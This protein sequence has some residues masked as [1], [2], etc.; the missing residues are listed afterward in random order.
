MKKSYLFGAMASAM[1]MFSACSSE[2]DVLVNDGSDLSAAKQEIVLQVKSTGTGLT[3]RAGRPLLS[4]AAGQ[5]IDNVVVFICDSEHKIEKKI[6]VEN[7]MNDAKPYAQGYEYPIEL[8]SGEKVELEGSGIVYAVGYSNGSFYNVEAFTGLDEGDYIDE[9]LTLKL[10]SGL[11]EEIFAGEI[12][13]AVND[14]GGFK[15][16]PVLNRQVA[17][18][19]GYFESIPYYE[20]AAKLRLVTYSAL[21]SNLVLGKFFNSDFET[22]GNN[23]TGLYAMNGFGKDNG[24][25]LY[26]IDLTKWFKTIQD[27]N[28]DGCIDKDIWTLDSNKM[29][30]L[31]KETD[32]NA[33]WNVSD[34]FVNDKASF[35]PGSVFAGNFIVPFA[36]A[37]QVDGKDVATLELQLLNSEGEILEIWDVNLPNGDTQLSNF[38]FSYVTENG[39]WGETVETYKDSKKSY[40]ILRNHLYAIGKRWIDDPYNPDPEPGPDKDDPEDVNK[41]QNLTLRVNDQWEV[42]HRM[43]ID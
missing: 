39:K 1:L 34:E 14:N 36:K 29:P 7:W 5:N 35:K 43:E 8:K 28:K 38:V 15:A 6:V 41:K 10:S 13:F 17:G 32:K 30:Y 25:T 27:V 21:N 40:N 31:A 33:N 22:N 4:D 12:E 26:E 16:T 37:D 20:N 23:L 11:G 24:T 42:L 19:Y 2:D 3:S 9:D 18:V